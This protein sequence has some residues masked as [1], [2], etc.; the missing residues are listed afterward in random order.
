M[1]FIIE[2]IHSTF[3][4]GSLMMAVNTISEIVLAVFLFNL[5]LFIKNFISGSI[6]DAISKAIIKGI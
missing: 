3:N 6:I 5:H 2:R 4:Y 1:K